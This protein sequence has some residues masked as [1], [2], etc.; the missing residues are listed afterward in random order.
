[1]TIRPST[2][3]QLE[4][5]ETLRTQLSSVSS[6]QTKDGHCLDCAADVDPMLRR[7]S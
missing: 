3:S 6:C 1:M 7:E 2:A 4:Q 5:T